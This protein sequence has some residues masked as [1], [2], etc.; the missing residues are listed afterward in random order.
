LTSGVIDRDAAR[1]LLIDSTGRVLLQE[2]E[3]LGD[4][5]V[6][7]TPGGGLEPGEAH[8]AAAMREIREEV[9]HHAAALGPCVWT[10]EHEFTFRGARYRQ[11]ER[12]FVV[13][14]EPFDVDE[15]GLDELETEVV[16]GHRWWTL[17]EIRNAKGTIFAPRALA[18]L[19]EPLLAGSLPASPVE[20]GV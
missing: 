16:K 1:I 8:E 5:T 9:G 13:R 11:R 2:V 6:W 3:G 17:G 15:S 10:R 7:I 4:G 14:C 12:F 18:D 20:V 19:L